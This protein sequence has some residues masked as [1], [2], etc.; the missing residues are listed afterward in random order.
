MIQHFHS[1]GITE[2]D[3][4]LYEMAIKEGVEL[5]DVW[6]DFSQHG[7]TGFFWGAMSPLLYQRFII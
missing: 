1:L 7:F 3:E 2:R 6:K 4:V 5:P